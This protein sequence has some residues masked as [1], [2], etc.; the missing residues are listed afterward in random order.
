MALALLSLVSGLKPGCFLDV[1]ADLERILTDPKPCSARWISTSQSPGNAGCLA[2][3]AYQVPCSY[4]EACSSVL[5]QPVSRRMPAGVPV[6]QHA[7]AG[8]CAGIRT[9]AYEEA[10]CG[11]LHA[12][13]HAAPMRLMYVPLWLMQCFQSHIIRIVCFNQTALDVA[14]GEQL[15]QPGAVQERC[16]VPARR[17]HSAGDWPARHSPLSAA[18]D[19][20]H[21]AE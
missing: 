2:N 11:P 7:A 13:F 18:P 21:H 4:V 17:R 12:V 16:R 6:L 5:P 9:A 14:A 10:A 1:L 20:V 8:R 19:K 3:A 15:P